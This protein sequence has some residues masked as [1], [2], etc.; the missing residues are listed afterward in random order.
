MQPSRYLN[1]ILTVNAVLLTAVLWNGIAERPLLSSTAHA[2]GVPEG[3]PNAGMQR[4][5]MIEGLRDVRSQLEAT[6][7]MLESGAIKVQVTNLDELKVASS[8]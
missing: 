8:K 3:V 5:Q 7:R 2:Q 6:R 4:H 1:V